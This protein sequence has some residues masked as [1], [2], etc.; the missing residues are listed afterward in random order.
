MK[1]FYHFFF[2]IEVF[3]QS[4][5]AKSEKKYMFETTRYELKYSEIY[6]L[7][8]KGIRNDDH[9]FKKSRVSKC[10]SIW[11]LVRKFLSFTETAIYGVNKNLTSL[12]LTEFKVYD[13]VSDHEIIYGIRLI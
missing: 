11:H 12:P 10:N 8:I 4:R 1:F 2:G 7:T 9:K 13:I 5:D 3:C 6:G